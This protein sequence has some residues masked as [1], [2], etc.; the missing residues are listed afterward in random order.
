MNTQALAVDEAA[1][2]FSRF[3]SLGGVAGQ[4]GALAA[5]QRQ[6]GLSPE[7]L[8]SQAEM[9]ETTLIH[10]L[11][12]R[13]EGLGDARNILV[14][15]WPNS[16]QWWASDPRFPLAVPSGIRSADRS[17]TGMTARMRRRWAVLRARLSATLANGD[18]V[19]VF[20]GADSGCLPAL[21]AALRHYPS[22][23][24]LFVAA[25]GD[26]AA[27][28][29]VTA[30]S[31][32]VLLAA[33]PMDADMAAWLEVCRHALACGS[34]RPQAT[35]PHAGPPDLARTAP[36]PNVVP[37]GAEI[38]LRPV[39]PP[40]PAA[41]PAAANRT[42]APVSRPAQA[43]AHTPARTA[44]P[45][46]ADRAAGAGDVE[47]RLRAEIARSPASTRAHDALAQYLTDQNR[48]PEAIAA[49]LASIALDPGNPLRLAQLGMLQM[50]ADQLADAV[51]TLRRAEALA[52]ESAG[53][54]GQLAVALLRQGDIQGALS[55]AR[56]SVLLDPSNPRR[57]LQLAGAL[58]AAADMPSAE[59]VIRGA[60]AMNPG[61]SDSHLALSVLLVRLGRL[62]EALAAARTAV[63]HQPNH[64]RALGQVGRIA[65]LLGDYDEAEA[66]L[67]R[68][69][70]VEPGAPNWTRLLQE[71]R[72]RRMRER[73]TPR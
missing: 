5:I 36:A 44:T 15:P 42:G 8:L 26:G 43:A 60:I 6:A 55:A 62:P 2:V 52:P 4:G 27:A 24:L 41:N 1:E 40:T 58:T 48:I 17:L 56:R 3:E 7:G 13:L 30:W 25:P 50:R 57:H 45:A 61:L 49:R 47:A 21:D 12:T 54:V 22:V 10:L 65:G 70:G 69:A 71:I 31:D 63:E 73:S 39:T 9:P 35:S 19:L 20:R 18:R 14:G 72:Q 64:V 33:L 23:R 16:D 51:E 59:E 38:P 32:R 28:G 66:A 46:P 11:R 29:A 67:T 53:I 68:A 37:G 34:A